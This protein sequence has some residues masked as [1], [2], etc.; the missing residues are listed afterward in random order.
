MT[1]T[2]AT[3]LAEQKVRAPS[4]RPSWEEP[5]TAAGQTGKG[6]VLIFTV[7]VVIVPLWMVVITSL[8]PQGAVNQA[9][10][11]VLVPHGITTAAYQ[12]IF[13]NQLIMHSLLVS[14]AVTLIGTAISMVVTILCAYGLSRP[15]SYA[16][17]PILMLLVVTMFFSGGLIPSFLVVTALGGYDSYWSMV[18]PSAVSVFNILVMR[19]FFAGTAQELIDAAAIDGA[20]E[21]RT[22]WSVVLPTSRAVVAVIALFYG[23]GYWNTFFNALLYLPDNQKWPLQMVIYTY[24]LQGNSMPGTG[25][26]NTGQYFGHQQIAPLAIQMAVVTLTLIPILLIYP[27]V[28]RHFTKGM[29]LGAIKG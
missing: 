23:V 18:L 17:R 25:V 21:W 9:S 1:T 20:S 27:F 19:G 2:T 29:L 7:A 24:T 26:T 8:S 28:Q 10:G 5:P 11:M 12:Q 14:L 16:H 13:T 22:L 3:D 6:A 4:N 15:G